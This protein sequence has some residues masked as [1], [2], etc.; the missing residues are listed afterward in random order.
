MRVYLGKSD[1]MR[2]PNPT[3]PNRLRLYSVHSAVNA[4]LLNCQVPGQP[5]QLAETGEG[6]SA[7]QTVGFERRVQAP[8][9]RQLLQP[10]GLLQGCHVANRV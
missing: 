3:F 5:V 4:A 6:R 9:L 7:H 1:L 2:C 8:Q 10:R